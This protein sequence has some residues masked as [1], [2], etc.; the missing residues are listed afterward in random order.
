MPLDRW[1]ELRE[2]VRQSRNKQPFLSL[3]QAIL[4]GPELVKVDRVHKTDLGRV[5]FEKLK[6]LPADHEA[7]K[8]MDFHHAYATEGMGLKIKHWKPLSWDEL[9]GAVG[10]LRSE[11]PLASTSTEFF[12]CVNKSLLELKKQGFVEKLPGKNYFRILKRKA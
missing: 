8:H 2:Q 1:N 6:Q 11:N 12:H 7:V 4:T 3:V 9:N 5:V 10:S